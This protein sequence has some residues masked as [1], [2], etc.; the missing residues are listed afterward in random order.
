MVHLTFSRPFVSM[1]D[2]DRICLLYWSPVHTTPKEC[3]NGGFTLKTHQMFSV[4]TTPEE[5]KNAAITGHFGFVFE[6]NSVREITW[7]SWRHRFRK[8]PFPKR[9]P[10]TRKR[11]A[12]VLKFLRFE[13]RFWKAPFSWRIIVDGKPNRRKKHPFSI[14]SATVWT[15]SDSL[16]FTDQMYLL[17]F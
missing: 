7:L 9:F 12:G 17:W 6:E 10:S 13:E 4:H 14:S 5:I 16:R 11:K 3:V 15:G 2:A 8:T 1:L